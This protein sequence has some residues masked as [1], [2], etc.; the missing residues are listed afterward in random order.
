MLDAAELRE[1][2]SGTPR[3]TYSFRHTYATLRLSEGI[4]VYLLAEQMGTSVKMI[5]DH[6]G[7][8]N[9]IKHADRLLQ[10]MG[11]WEPIE[12]REN[13]PAGKTKT[14]AKA[15][16]SKAATTRGKAARPAHPRRPRV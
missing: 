9:T 6:Y 5:E 2:P 11:G 1:G 3:S 4:D 15:H 7:H 14:A 16:A 12:V 10:G 13:Q 8:V